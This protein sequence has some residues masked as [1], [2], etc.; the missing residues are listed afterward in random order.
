VVHVRVLGAFGVVVDG[1]EIESS[2]WP[3]RRAIELV[4][5]LALARGH[6]L[7]ADQVIEALWSGLDADAGRANLHKAASYTR[8]ALEQRDAIVLRGGG[9]DLFPNQDVSVDAADFEAEARRALAEDDATRCADIADSYAGDLLPDLLY[10]DWTTVHRERL[11]RLHHDLLR[12]AG[13][14]AELVELDPRDE[15]AHRGLM[16]DH[17]LHGRLHAAIRQF[18]RLRAVLATELRVA[19]SGETLRLYRSIV[20]TSPVGWIRPALVG[21][22]VELVRARAALRRATEERPAAIVVS[23]PA[24]IGKTRLCEELADG[25]KIFCVYIAPDEDRV[26]EHATRGGFPANAVLEVTQIIDPTTGGR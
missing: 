3:S 18:Q 5:L 6:R 12:R 13:R 11:R 26:R 15:E 10:E 20:G 16:A 17:H 21:R 4:A 2:A 22:E 14:W 7:P 19:P 1:R 24:G 25:D 9:V 8:R 23:G